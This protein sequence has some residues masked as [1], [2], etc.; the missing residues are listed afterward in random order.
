ML[1]KKFDPAALRR[2]HDGSWQDEPAV[3]YRAPVTD[4]PAVTSETRRSVYP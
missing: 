4:G 1:M 2:A 3:P